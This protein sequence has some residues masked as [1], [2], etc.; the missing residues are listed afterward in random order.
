M[1]SLTCQDKKLIA[2]TGGIG[3]GKTSVARFIQVQSGCTC[4]SADVV[5]RRLLLPQGRGWFALRDFLGDGFFTKHNTIDTGLVRRAIFSD[6]VTRKQINSILHPIIRE[7]IQK[8][9][10]ASLAGGVCMVVIEVPLL[11]EAS[12]QNDFERL[13]VVYARPEVCV[14]RL[15]TRDGFSQDEAVRMVA[16]QMPSIAKALLADHVID[17]SGPWTETCFQVLHLCRIITAC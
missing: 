5:N 8:D 9:I 16:V 7:E 12:W 2:I 13:V 10:A 14:E 1:R 3:S 4:I 11:F 6:P 17:N 15:T